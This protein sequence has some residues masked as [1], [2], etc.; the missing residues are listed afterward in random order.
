MPLKNAVKNNGRWVKKPRLCRVNHLFE[1]VAKWAPN[2]AAS[3]FPHSV[4][5]GMGADMHTAD[6]SRPPVPRCWLK[7]RMLITHIAGDNLFTLCR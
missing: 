2:V 5:Y 3:G 1:P 4:F 6:K 7:K